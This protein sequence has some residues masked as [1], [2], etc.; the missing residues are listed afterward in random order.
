MIECSQYRR[1]LLAEPDSADPA[2]I[3]HRES[4]VQCAQF[5][6][7]VVRFEARLAGALRLDVGATAPGG[8]AADNVVPLRAK[9]A[10]PGRR[11]VALAASV[12]VAAGAAGLMWLAFPRASLAD[13]VVAHMAGEPQAWTSEGPVPAALLREA[14]G[15]ARMRLRS[16]AGVVSY[17]ASCDFRGHQVPH[18]VVQDASGP[19]TVMVLVHESARSTVNFDEQGYRGVIRPVPG[20]GAI[21]VLTR[22][23]ALSGADVDRIAAHVQNAIDWTS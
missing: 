21:A 15:D 14:I 2:L 10:S 1:A 16:D 3:A 22:N 8:A 13:A 9:R 18:L 5:T 23:R 20:H 6:R 7:G 17:A 19:V 11:W 4:C 12:L